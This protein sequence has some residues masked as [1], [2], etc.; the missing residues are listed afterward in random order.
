MDNIT[1]WRLWT[2]MV[3]GF[4]VSMIC[5]MK[6]NEGVELPQR[7]PA[8]VFGIVWP[9]LYFL[10]GYSWTQSTNISNLDFM[11]MIVTFLLASW[12]VFFSCLGNKKM[13]IY[14][15]ASTIAC[16]VSCMTLHIDN[17]SKIALTP[18]LGWLL[19]AFQLNWNL[20]K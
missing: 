12:L 20:V 3:S 5:K 6:K 2:P 17:L 7:P 9:I 1:N 18:L 13:G 11:H 10:L 19:V 4:G 8:F 16:V 14:I 15:I